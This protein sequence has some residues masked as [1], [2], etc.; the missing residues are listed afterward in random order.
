M[1]GHYHGALIQELVRHGYA[2]V[3][4]PAGIVSQIEDEAFD[5]VLSEFVERGLQI[6]AGI[7]DELLDLDIRDARLEP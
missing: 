5:V 2:F 7:F 3:Q 4:E 1:M 6:S